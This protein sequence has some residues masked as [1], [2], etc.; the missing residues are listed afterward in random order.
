VFF[1]RTKE[2]AVAEP[3]AREE[4]RGS[5]PCSEPGCSASDAAA[6]AYVDRRQRDCGTAW[7]VEHQ[8]IVDHEVFCRRHEGIMNALGSEHHVQGRPDLENRSPSLANWVGRE[9]D[10]PIRAL[11]ASHFPGRRLNVTSVVV[12]GSPRDRTWGRSWKLVSHNGV[13]LSVSIAVPEADDSIVRIIYDG[14]P[15][16]EVTPPWIEARRHGIRLSDEDD[17]EARRRFY[18]LILEDIETSMLVS[19]RRPEFR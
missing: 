14:N 18:G 7:C 10:D 5:L 4:Y 2:V 15:I 6:C 16:L 3:P 11:L 17:A 9:L 19:K 12:G 1:R 13:D 8:Q